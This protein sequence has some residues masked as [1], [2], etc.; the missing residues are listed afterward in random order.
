MTNYG[1]AS[2]MR[3]YATFS[4]RSPRKE[5][6]MFTLIYLIIGF[7]A[8]IIDSALFG[9]T[10]G[11]ETIGI[12]GGIVALAH[13][14]PSIAVGVRRLHDIGRTGWWMLIAFIPLLG[15]IVL[16]VFFCFNSEEGENQYGLHPYGG[17]DTDVF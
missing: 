9:A 17:V 2:A 7:V 10:A 12:V 16:L 14:I 4:G 11:G 5:F 15:F 6:W 13:L 3:K 8:G 1:Y